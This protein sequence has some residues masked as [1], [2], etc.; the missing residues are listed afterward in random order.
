MMSLEH[1]HAFAKPL[2]VQ[3][4]VENIPNELSTPEALMEL[5]HAGRFTDIGVCFDLGHAHMASGVKQSFEVL[6]DRIRSTHVHDNKKDHDSHLWPGAGQHRLEGSDGV[7]AQQ[8]R[9]F[10]RCCWRSKASKAKRCRRRW[11][12]H[13][14][15]WN[16]CSG[17]TSLAHLVSG[18][19][20]PER[21]RAASAAPES[22]DPYRSILTPPG[23][24]DIHGRSRPYLR[25]SVGH[26]QR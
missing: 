16:R 17:S 21:R 7:A 19:V 12:R 14:E 20:T 11:R 26:C 24:L 22:K 15:C 10:R 9:A 13:S 6:Q 1:L 5:L 4:L 2:G 8:L 18:V 3:L 23:F 25:R